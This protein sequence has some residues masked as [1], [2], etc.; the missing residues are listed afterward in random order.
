M[1]SK[2]TVNKWIVSFLKAVRLS[3]QELLRL[4]FSFQNQK[5]IPI[6][7]FHIQN[8]KLKSKLVNIVISD[9]TELHYLIEEDHILHLTKKALSTFPI[10][11]QLDPREIESLSIDI[12]MDALEPSLKFEIKGKIFD[13]SPM[14][15]PE[16]LHFTKTLPIHVEIGALFSVHQK[17]PIFK[18]AI[19]LAHWG[20]RVYCAF[21]EKST[22][23]FQVRHFSR[24]LRRLKSFTYNLLGSS[25]DEKRFENSLVLIY[26]NL[27][28]HS[29]LRVDT[30]CKD[31][32]TSRSFH[33]KYID[34]I[35][36]PERTF[37]ST[38]GCFSPIKYTS[39]VV[40]NE[41]IFNAWKNG[42]L[43]E[44]FAASVLK[45]SGFDQALWNIELPGIQCDVIALHKD[46]IVVIECKRTNHYGDAYKEGIKHLEEIKQFFEGDGISTYT[47]LMTT[48][49]NTPRKEKTI[50]LVITQDN[51]ADFCEN[52]TSLF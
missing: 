2:G 29:S 40:S 51:F 25:F 43:M 38:E 39:F 6:A 11:Y 47:I 30:M 3:E 19:P 15:T 20:N 41:K 28:P 9:L 35:L 33:E 26:Y 24:N 45:K 8:G 44:W 14:A 10:V 16:V 32:H 50:D 49:H 31:G 34:G 17:N 37:C 52:P 12:Q 46:E 27:L 22:Q 4:L 23:E 48:I 7:P 42:V 36:A 21:V 13:Y 18:S 5:L 1:L